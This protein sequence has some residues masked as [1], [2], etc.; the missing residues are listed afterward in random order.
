M[1]TLINW[2]NTTHVGFQSVELAKAFIVFILFSVIGWICEVIYVGVFSEHKFVNRGF[3]HGPL[4]PIYGVG[5]LLILML[6]VRL[7]NPVWVLFIS[8]TFFCS[9]VEYIGSWA[10]EKMFHTTWW[11]YSNHKIT[12]KGK[13]IPLNIRGRVCLKNSLL[14]GVMSVVGIK[15]VQPLIEKFLNLFSDLAL[16][17]ISDALL[18]I[19]IVDLVATVHKLVDF[20]VYMTKLKEFGESLKDRYEKESWFRSNSLKDMIQSVKEHSSVE[21]E[22]FSSALLEKLEKINLNHKASESL[23]KRFPKMKSA[24]FNAP[25][26]MI[27]EKLNERIAEKKDS[28]K[29]EKSKK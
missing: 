15:F 20:S 9:V 8:G 22:K 27:K 23:M 29:K 10:L 3:L 12:I 14:F 17:I 11:D 21:R 7:Q 18:V 13:T 6:P 1:E 26:S 16:I 19:F 2:M 28:K 25:L 4:C 5:G 24:S